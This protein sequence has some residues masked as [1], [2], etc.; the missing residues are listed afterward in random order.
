MIAQ[1]EVKTQRKLANKTHNSTV[2][3]KYRRGRVLAQ[4]K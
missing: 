3:Y 2:S 4:I 1:N